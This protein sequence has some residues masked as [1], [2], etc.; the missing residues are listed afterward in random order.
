MLRLGAISLSNNET[1]F[2]LFNYTYQTLCPFKICSSI[3]HLPTTST[4]NN[5]QSLKIAIKSL[6]NQNRKYLQLHKQKRG[7]S[8]CFTVGNE[9]KI[10]G[11]EHRIWKDDTKWVTNMVFSGCTFFLF[12]MRLN[13]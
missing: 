6:P 13:I 3:C 11:D 4:S 2:S 10:E 7:K 12:F 5:G 9:N 8:L 1:L